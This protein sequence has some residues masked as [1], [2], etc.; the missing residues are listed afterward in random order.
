MRLVITG[1]NGQ[2]AQCLLERASVAPDVR[3]S[4][5]GRPEVDLAAP[6]DLAPAIARL[7]PDVIV[8]AAAYTAVDKAESETEQAFAVNRDGARAVAEASRQLG[9]PLIHI[10][11]DYVYAGDKDAPYVEDDPTGPLGVYGQSKLEGELAV[12]SVQPR[13]A[14]L[15]TSWV[16]SPFG[17]N[18]VKTMLRLAGTRDEI[19]VVADQHGNP[20]SALDLADAVLAVARGMTNDPNLTG[21]FHVAGRGET[22]WCGFAQHVFSVSREAGGPYAQ[23]LPIKT[24]DYPTAARRPANSRLDCAKFEQ[25]FGV[26][27]PHWRDS[28][29]L[30]V[31]RLLAG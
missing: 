14:I 11:T 7:K 21:T 24:S 17:A 18:F 23:V 22:T 2:V 30:C 26:V 27:Q 28:S 20:T 31:R 1:K 12:Q 3:V 5:I 6:G 8:N 16:Y 15:R 29:A 4:C 9:V 10:S 25:V 13:H 19:S